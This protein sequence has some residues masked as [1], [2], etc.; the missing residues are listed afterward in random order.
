MGCGASYLGEF[1][2][3]EGPFARVSTDD[4][5]RNM[6]TS[7]QIIEQYYGKQAT[8]A[9]MATQLGGRVKAKHRFKPMAE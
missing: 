8:P 9:M 5:A 6:G 3:S 4:A 7:V 1:C 2:L